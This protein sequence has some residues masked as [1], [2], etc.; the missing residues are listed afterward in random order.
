VRSPARIS[1]LMTV[2][3]V[4]RGAIDAVI[5]PFADKRRNFLYVSNDGRPDD[6]RVDIAHESLIRNW[7]RLVGWTET[8]NQVRETFVG[9][10][11][12]A[13]RWRTGSGS[14]LEGPERRT[15]IAWATATNPKRGWAQRYAVADDDYDA[16]F[17]YLN[18]SQKSLYRFRGLTIALPV[19]VL[20]SAS[21]LFG[22]S[23]NEKLNERYAAIDRSVR[24]V[25]AMTTKM[26]SVLEP[27]QGS[28]DARRELLQG[29]RDF[30]ATLNG[31]N[32]D[33]DSFDFWNLILEGDTYI[34]TLVD[35]DDPS[36][37][38]DETLFQAF[39]NAR[40]KYEAA[41]KLARARGNQNPSDIAWKVYLA[42]GLG[43]L[44]PTTDTPA[45][46]CAMQKEVVSLNDKIRAMDDATYDW[47]YQSFMGYNYLARI[48]DNACQRRSDNLATFEKARHLAETI[49]KGT[50]GSQSRLLAT[51]YELLENSR[52][53][54]G[55]PPVSSKQSL[56]EHN[57][58]RDET[59][60][61]AALAVQF[62]ARA[63]AAKPTTS[64]RLELAKARYELGQAL[65]NARQFRKA[66]VLF[67][68]A[69]ADNAALAK[70][71]PANSQY[72]I[73]EAELKI[74]IAN[75]AACGFATSDT[76]G[77]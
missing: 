15:A 53:L 16:L 7:D 76:A 74:A 47:R 36:G 29:S 6:P 11:G 32:N 68:T 69:L 37:V 49:T 48:M 17:A 56:R 63:Q 10:V 3:G 77:C 13:R 23:E 27:L 67:E 42:I 31:Y 14:L 65:V 34:D 59:V 55:F 72:A 58:E 21:V 57:A 45:A 12:R 66:I 24:L 51:A 1:E 61:Q 75:I 70:A 46:T 41:V 44:A 22:F 30:G 19:A 38:G 25:E 2:A 20:L 8:E 28:G 73:A 43:K 52:Q 60:A 35:S 39:E 4:D 54:R 18:A 71:D 9:L 5:A 33:A 26:Y 40:G 50:A 62:L 64:T